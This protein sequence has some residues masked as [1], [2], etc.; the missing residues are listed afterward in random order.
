MPKERRD[1]QNLNLDTGTQTAHG[2]GKTGHREKYNPKEL[3]PN[4]W[5]RIGNK[6]RDKS[7]V[8]GNLLSHIK[9][10]SLREAFNALDGS[11]ALGVDGISKS[12]YGRKLEE[13]LRN[14]EQRIQRGSYK[15]MPKREVLIP[16]GNGKMRPIAIGCFEDK[17][18]DWVVS[19]I[20]TEVYEPLFIRNSFGYRPGKSPH[21]AVEACYYSLC[22]NNR[23][24][25]VEIDFSSFFN[26]IPHRKLMK[27]L[28]KR[29]S[30]RKFKGLIGRFLKGG[31]ITKPGRIVPG[32]LGT[33][34]GSIMSP[35][36]ANIYLNEAV[37]QWF[38]NNHGS[39]SNIIVRY[40]D[41]AVFFFR[42][43]DDRDN[44]LKEFRERMQE[45][46]LSLNE[47][48]TRSFRLTKNNHE[49]FNFLGFTFYWG[50]QSSR[51]ILKVKTQKE[52]LIKS[53][54]EFYQWIK[55]VRSQKKL[56]KLWLTAKSKIQGHINY[57]GY[58]MNLLKLNHFYYEAIRA[59]F[60]WLNRRSHK[61]SY[62]WEG[63]KERLRNFP[64]M[65]PLDVR[66]LKPLG[67][68]LYAIR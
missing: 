12:E 40:A 59:L 38:I 13:N 30:D 57:Y 6:A 26:T 17:L 43:E 33:P 14:L 19:K 47:E 31:L 55:R 28:G 61:L 27:I 20:L 50:K 48:K 8:F 21:Q 53:I 68:N 25:A 2:C 35:I 3:F 67:W 45:Y 54:R 52:K 49:Q 9:I 34:Q 58:W 37:D 60:K 66:K 65:E 23:Q 46:K 10:D 64:L 4:R 16:K 39:Y 24:Y 7:T 1:R 62:N 5:S 63:F 15:P 29:I 36:L 22:K 11:K 42:R 51:T 41:D 18:V 56:K 44:F 32:E